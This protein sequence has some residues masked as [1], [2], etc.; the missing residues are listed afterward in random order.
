VL[1]KQYRQ[2]AQLYQNDVLL[3]P[4]GDDFRYDTT[5][6]WDN[7]FNNY[8]KLFDY[9]NGHSEWNIEVM[10]GKCF[11]PRT[12]SLVIVRPHMLR[13]HR[14]HPRCCIGAWICVCGHTCDIVIYTRFN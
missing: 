9:M 5:D 10:L 8:Q 14:D 7:Q 13:V 12:L 6:E 4:L 3:V 2:K 11:S 1:L